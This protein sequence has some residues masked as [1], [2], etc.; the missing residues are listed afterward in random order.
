MQTCLQTQGSQGAKVSQVDS[1]YPRGRDQQEKK[2]S[3][4]GT[5]AWH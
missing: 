4:E 5:D 1:A 2:P 3:R